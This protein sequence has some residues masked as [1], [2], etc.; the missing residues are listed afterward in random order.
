[1]SN[2]LIIS[3]D[4]ATRERWT[5]L[6]ASKRVVAVAGEWNVGP[7]GG[8]DKTLFGDGPYRVAFF[9]AATVA[10]PIGSALSAIAKS[11]PSAQIVLV[12]RFPDDLDPKIAAGCAAVVKRERFEDAF[13]EALRAVEKSEASKPRRFDLESPRLR[14]RLIGE[15]PRIRDLE[16]NLD[17][18]A[19]STK[20]ILIL[21]ERGSGRSL[22]AERIASS[23][24]RANAPYLVVDCA[25][26]PAT[27]LE[28]ELFGGGKTSGKIAYVDACGGTLALD[29]FDRI[30]ASLERAVLS[31]AFGRS[32][33][34]RGATEET[35]VERARFVFIGEPEAAGAEPPEWREFFNAAGLTIYSP[36]LRELT[37]KDLREIADAAAARA[38][39]VVGR[40]VVLDETAKAAAI[41]AAKSVA[42]LTEIVDAA[43][44]LNVEGTLDAA[45]LESAIKR[46]RLNRGGASGL[47][48]RRFAQ[49][50]KDAL[51]EALNA[52]EGNRARTAR[53]LDV[54][55]KTIF[56][57]LREFNL[58]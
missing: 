45:D 16:R 6:C 43:V 25:N 22:I 37:P 17:S 53:M 19:T 31:V 12:C 35:A 42:E 29:S 2:A 10:I 18:V 26:V 39:A 36:S 28:R 14:R 5:R 46:T 58:K 57:W 55:E 34:R 40:D 47:A 54:S 52:C 8:C 9:D 15:R 41:R 38:R 48:G 44:A 20:P 21:G 13:D 7:D 23:G 30:P 3:N 51:V 27:T 50:R 32:F 49:I 24:V 1:M 33:K 11:F 4:G 56:N